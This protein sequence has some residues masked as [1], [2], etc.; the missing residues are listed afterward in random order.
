MEPLAPPDLQGKDFA[1]ALRAAVT[2]RGLS[3]SRLRA[4]LAEHGISVST[5][6]LSYWQSGRSRPE[7]AASRAAIGPLEDVLELPRGFL[8]VRL[9][10]R[11]GVAAGGDHRVGLLQRVLPDHW[12]VIEEAY[13]QLGLSTDDVLSRVSVHDRLRL[14]PKGQQL[15]HQVRML[16][17]AARDGVDRF[18]VWYDTD[19]PGAFGAVTAQHNCRLGRTVEFP[20][21]H[22]VAAEI[23][24]E[25]PLWAG[26]SLLVGYRLE[27]LGAIVP[28]RRIL[29]GISGATRELLVEVLFDRGALP[30]RAEDVTIVDGVESV[31]ARPVSP[32]LRLL[33]FDRPGGTYGLRWTW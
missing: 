13:A 16:L 10:T 11:A 12:S 33:L 6:T 28:Q 22:G 8:A 32:S 5:A 30:A 21:V 3:L 29:R 14:G 23:L 31:R 26:E 19:E 25:R 4:R 17:V 1:G 24:L 27:A 18:G 2:A 7:R 9:P 15:G 20:Q